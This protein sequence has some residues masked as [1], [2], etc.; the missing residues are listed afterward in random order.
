MHFCM[1]F[2]RLLAK[3]VYLCKWIALVLHDWTLLAKKLNNWINIVVF[4]NATV[5]FITLVHAVIFRISQVFA[6]CNVTCN[7]DLCIDQIYDDLCSGFKKVLSNRSYEGELSFL[8]SANRDSHTRDGTVCKTG[9]VLS[10]Y[11]FYWLIIGFSS[12]RL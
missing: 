12:L 5:D 10:T 2:F 11:M 1:L 6:F 9:S 3:S 4:E 7:V 8:P